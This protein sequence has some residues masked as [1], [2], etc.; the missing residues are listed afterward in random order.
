RLGLVDEWLQQLPDKAIRENARLSLLYGETCGIRGAWTDALEA[1]ERARAYFARKGDR[2]LEA[3]ACLKLSSVHSNYGD[4]EKAAQVAEAGVELVPEDAVATRLRLEGNLAI[5]RTWLTQ[6][7]E[8]VLRECQRIA[9]EAAA[10][11]LEHFA[12]VAH[13]NI[14][15]LA[16]RM[17]RVTEAVTNL[18]LAARFWS[19]PPTSPFADNSELAAALV[20]A[21]RLDI[22]SMAA[23][24]GVRRTRPWRR[25]NADALFGLSAVQ[26]A[27][28][29]IDEAIATLEQANAEPEILGVLHGLIHARL[30]EAL[31]LRNAGPERIAR[32]ASDLS[33]RVTDPRY[34]ADIAPARAL[35]IHASGSCR[36][37][38][39]Q[40]SSALDEAQRR[41]AEA[42]ARSGRLKL[43]VLAMEHGGAHNVRFAWDS[44]DAVEASGL[45]GLKAWKRLYAR[46][47]R[48]LVR[49]R[50][51]V[52]LL[53]L[54]ADS[55]PEGWRNALAQAIS[56]TD[57]TDRRRL[58][59]AVV[60]HA[61]RETIDALKAMPG[62][63][64]AE[65]RKRLMHLQAARLFLRTFG[66]VRLHRGSW[67]GPELKIEKRRVRTLLAVL[68]AYAHTNLTRDMAIELLWPDAD[69]DSAVNS[70]NQTV[71][72][73][74]RYID[75]DYR[76]G[77]SPEYV[78]STSE[79]VALNTE[80]VMTDLEDLRRL[81]SRLSASDWEH[82]QVAA[83]RAVELVR[84]EFLADVRYE[85]WT[86]TH[87][88]A[89]HSEVR[90]RLLP[91]ALSPVTGYE[92]EISTQAATALLAID[93][94]DEQATLALAE[95]LALSGRRVAAR[96][97]VV[98]F[99]QR[100]QAELDEPPSPELAAR[101]R[102]LGAGGLSSGV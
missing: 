71:F 66:G 85:S 63:D 70:L 30:I 7:Y 9:V 42:L 38:C 82:R 32:A 100:L 74:R 77:E 10:R 52:Q 22:A 11:G 40:L 15:A 90:E 36:G 2:R 48:S 81:P 94:F 26:L 56:W 37:E 43:G 29:R 35:A 89:I 31:Y 58:V 16:I 20:A 18:E 76:G 23:D 78:I 99:A 65:A 17:G 55:D 27:D 64:V 69:A 50:G 44:L 24:E 60:K 84:G 19:D 25:P 73:L 5:T 4:A 34:A 101:A 12:A 59:A 6:P 3:L 68:A 93:P 88:M 61:N 95:C 57:A 53:C 98:G 39:L 96:D 80:L 47:V 79:Q 92:V 62:K 8:V 54:L 28:G 83:R 72:Q 102:L 46:H 97:L 45:A 13:H 91:I 67:V 21:G 51:G 86:A 49:R 1:L 14:G 33:S 75:P 41:G 87:Q